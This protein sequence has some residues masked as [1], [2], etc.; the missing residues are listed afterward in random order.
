MAETEFGGPPCWLLSSST[1]PMGR[2]GRAVVVM[3]EAVENGV[4]NN[5][6]LEVWRPRDGQ[7]LGDALMWPSVVVED[8]EVGEEPLHVLR[9]EQEEVVEQLAAQRADEAL[10]E[11]V[12]VRSTD[13]AA[14]E[15]GAGPFEGGGEAGA[16]LRV[17]VGDEHLGMLVHGRIASLLCAPVVGRGCGGRNVNDP[18]AP[19][20]KKEEDEDRPE[21][22]VERCEG[23]KRSRLPRRRAFAAA[24]CSRSISFSATSEARERAKPPTSRSRTRTMLEATTS[25]DGG[26]AS[27]GWRK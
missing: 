24:N 15:A 17:A 23:V 16:E 25:R 9:V 22:H 18:A 27:C 11:G 5:L 13:G 12:H 3:V 21:E 6:S 4:R 2:Y 20:I 19:D 10:G 14:G 26:G 7:L 8:D 1:E